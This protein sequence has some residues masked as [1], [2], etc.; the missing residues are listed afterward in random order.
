M[1]NDRDRILMMPRV[2]IHWATGL[3]RKVLLAEASS[4]AGRGG[5][6]DSIR[7]GGGLLPLRHLGYGAA[8][9]TSSAPHFL[10]R[11]A[12]SLAVI[13]LAATGGCLFGNSSTVHRTGIDVPESTFEQ[14]RPGSTTAAW[15]RATLGEPTSKSV[16]APSHDEV[17]AYAYTERVDSSGYVFL[18]FGGSNTTETTRRAFVEFKDGIVVRKWRG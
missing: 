3:S 8:M 15:V 7:V 17:W 10:A 4:P 11:R 16:D 12:S 14:V 9:A 5:H 18:I 13:L 1:D 6:R 2:P